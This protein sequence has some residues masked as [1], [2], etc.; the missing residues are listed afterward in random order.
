MS[1]YRV[2][3][4]GGGW[5]WIGSEDQD[6]GFVAL[7]PNYG[8]ISHRIVEELNGLVR[9]H[10]AQKARAEKAEA[11]LA[12]ATQ[13]HAHERYQLQNAAIVAVEAQ[14]KAE[15]RVAELEREV[16]AWSPA[17]HYGPEDDAYD[18]KPIWHTLADGTRIPRCPTH[19]YGWATEEWGASRP[20]VLLRVTC[21]R[22]SWASGP[23]ERAAP[24]QCPT[25]ASGGDHGPEG[26]EGAKTPRPVLGHPRAPESSNLDTAYP[27]G[28][29]SGPKVPDRIA[30]FATPEADAFRVY[31]EMLRNPGHPQRGLTTEEVDLTKPQTLRAY[32]TFGEASPENSIRILVDPAAAA[33]VEARTG[34]YVTRLAGVVTVTAIDGVIVEV[35]HPRAGL[36]SRDEVAA[37]LEGLRR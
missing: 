7:A 1:G 3:V 27:T 32:A 34:A 26:G 5:R 29:S 14:R 28:E 2:K 23:I 8:M 36:P 13:T 15:A 25:G 4:D 10:D 17:R 20:P 37:F 18:P 24:P 31:D 6:T 19:G 33:E 9:E 30:W 12:D 35:R 11:A 16:A 21:Q 22:C